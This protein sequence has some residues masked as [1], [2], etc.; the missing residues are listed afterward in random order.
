MHSLFKHV[1][2]FYLMVLLVLPLVLVPSMSGQATTG[3]ISGTV[4]DIQGA[5]ISNATVTVTNT[6]TGISR[7]IASDEGGRYLAASLI[8]GTY[9]ISI[10]STG[11]KTSQLKGITLNIGQVL[12]E[13]LTL[14]IGGA[15]ETVSV[16]AGAST[17]ATE[18]ST[19]S[20]GTVIDNKQVVELPLANRQ[21]YNLTE[22]APGVLPPAQNSTLRLPRRLQRQRRA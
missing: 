6:G 10:E 14:Q 5:A 21:F 17:V 7:K 3:S 1:R 2:V 18:T 11:F 15:T 8:P 16:E 20:N 13:N 19:S 9:E 12:A 4:T 22:I